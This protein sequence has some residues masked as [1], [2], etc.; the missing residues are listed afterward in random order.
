[1]PI[2]AGGAGAADIPILQQADQWS[3]MGVRAKVFGVLKF[4][5]CRADHIYL[6][7]STGRMNKIS[8]M[9]CTT[10]DAIQPSR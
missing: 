6:R 4:F 5:A 2:T 9:S 3:D 8:Y 10:V 1:M 7:N